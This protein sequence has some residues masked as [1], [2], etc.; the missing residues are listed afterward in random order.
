MVDVEKKFYK[1]DSLEWKITVPFCPENKLSGVSNTDFLSAEWYRRKYGRQQCNALL[2]T[3]YDVA[4]A[5]I[6]P[7]R[8]GT[9]TALRAGMSSSGVLRG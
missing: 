8:G 7:T 4:R 3:V 2:D 6:P 9:A 1:R 5:A